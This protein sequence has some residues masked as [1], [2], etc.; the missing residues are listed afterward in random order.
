[1]NPNAVDS[2]T[3]NGAHDLFR[4]TVG[5]YEQFATEC[6]LPKDAFL[7][8]TDGAE[9]AF[10]DQV[11]AAILSLRSSTRPNA[12]NPDQK[13]TDDPNYNPRLMNLLGKIGQSVV[14]TLIASAQSHSYATP[15]K[16]DEILGKIAEA[17]RPEIAQTEA[18][19]ARKAK[20]GRAIGYKAFK[21]IVWACVGRKIIAKAY[22]NAANGVSSG[23]ESLA[24]SVNVNYDLPGGD[25]AANTV[26]V[27]PKKI[28]GLTKFGFRHFYQLFGDVGKLYSDKINLLPELVMACETGYSQ[29]FNDALTSVYPD[30]FKPGVDKNGNQTGHC[31]AFT[32]DRKTLAGIFNRAIRVVC[33]DLT[34]AVEARTELIDAIG[35]LENEPVMNL[36]FDQFLGMNRRESSKNGTVTLKTDLGVVS[37]ETAKME[38]GTTGAGSLNRGSDEGFM[39]ATGV[40]SSTKIENRGVSR[41]ANGSTVSLNVYGIDVTLSIDDSTEL[42]NYVLPVVL[43]M[44]FHGHER[45]W[46]VC[47]GLAPFTYEVDGGLQQDAALADPNAPA[48]DAASISE[49]MQHASENT[50]AGRFGRVADQISN[51]EP[52]FN[53]SEADRAAVVSD[54]HSRAESD[55]KLA[56]DASVA[57]G[58]LDSI[59]GSY[60]QFRHAVAEAF[61]PGSRNGTKQITTGNMIDVVNKV[62]KTIIID[63]LMG[64]GSPNDERAIREKTMQD[65]KASLISKWASGAGYDI[66]R[67]G[68]DAEDDKVSAV[69]ALMY[70]QAGAMGIARNIFGSYMQY[71]G[72]DPAKAVEQ[73]ES[74]AGLDQHAAELKNLVRRYIKAASIVGTS[75]TPD[76]VLDLLEQVESGDLAACA[77]LVKGSTGWFAEKLTDQMYAAARNQFD[78]WCLGF[79]Y[80]NLNDD[81]TP[82]RKV[83]E[84]VNQFYDSVA[85]AMFSKYDGIEGRDAVKK[86]VGAV[87]GALGTGAGTADAQGAVNEMNDFYTFSKVIELAAAATDSK[88]TEK[89]TGVKAVAS[90]FGMKPQFIE[91]PSGVHVEQPE[92]QKAPQVDYSEVIEE[93]NPGT[94]EAYG[95]GTIKQLVDRGDAQ[96][97]AVLNAMRLY[98]GSRAQIG[99]LEEIGDTTRTPASAETLI[100]SKVSNLVDKLITIVGDGMV[101]ASGNKAPGQAVRSALTTASAELADTERLFKFNA[102]PLFEKIL[103]GGEKILG[104]IESQQGEVTAPQAI[105]VASKVISGLDDALTQMAD[106][107]VGSLGDKATGFAGRKS[108]HSVVD[109]GL[110]N[111][112]TTDAAA[113][114]DDIVDS[115]ARLIVSPKA[116]N[117]YKDATENT[118]KAKATTQEIH[119]TMRFYNAAMVHRVDSDPS[120]R[121]LAAHLGQMLGYVSAD[122]ADDVINAKDTSGKMKRTSLK[123][124]PVKAFTGIAGNG[125]MN[126]LVNDIFDDERKDDKEYHGT[127]GDIVALMRGM[128]VGV[129]SK[130]LSVSSPDPES[131][132]RSRGDYNAKTKKVQVHYGP[133]GQ[134][135]TT[136]GGMTFEDIA[137]ACGVDGDF[138]A[139]NVPTDADMMSLIAAIRKTVAERIIDLS[140]DT[141][142]TPDNMGRFNSTV[143]ARRTSDDETLKSQIKNEL[144]PAVE[145]GS[146]P[147]SDLVFVMNGD[148]EREAVRYEL[149]NSGTKMYANSKFQSNG[150]YVGEV[151]PTDLFTAERAGKIFKVLSQLPSDMGED[152]IR[153]LAHKYF[154]ELGERDEIRHSRPEV[155]K[156]FG[157]LEEYDLIDRNDAT[158]DIDKIIE[159]FCDARSRA[160]AKN[161]TAGIHNEFGVKV[162]AEAAKI[163]GELPDNVSGEMFAKAFG[164]YFGSDASREKLKQDDQ[165]VAMVIA[166]LVDEHVI[167]DYLHLPDG[168]DQAAAVRSKERFVKESRAFIDQHNT[169]YDMSKAEKAIDLM[170]APTPKDMPQKEASAYRAKQVKEAATLFPHI[171]DIFVKAKQSGKAKT[172]DE[173]VELMRKMCREY[174]KVNP[175]DIKPDLTDKETAGGFKPNT[176]V[177]DYINMN[178]VSEDEAKD[179]VIDSL[180][181]LGVDIKYDTTAKDGDGYV[182]TVN[183]FRTSIASAMFDKAMKKTAVAVYGGEDARSAV[184]STL[185]AFGVKWEPV[186]KETKPA[187]KPVSPVSKA[188]NRYENMAYQRLLADEEKADPSKFKDHRPID[189]ETDERLMAEAE[190][191]SQIE[192]DKAKASASGQADF[193]KKVAA[194]HRELMA[195]QAAKYKEL[196]AANDPNAEAE[197]PERKSTQ[198]FNEARKFVQTQGGKE[199]K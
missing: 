102:A 70:D 185:N 63:M 42:D 92:A 54:I 35:T 48:E 187:P 174:A 105:F 136:P 10:M 190:R 37:I 129:Y 169:E 61:V 81:N 175:D 121:K 194:K 179:R 83:I 170:C 16:T 18:E 168:A 162:R 100:K 186:S 138:S 25:S 116:N 88:P 101:K 49:T 84:S 144:M 198:L 115:F 12:A 189:P 197:N 184:V 50:R 156:V 177:M 43:N 71:A 192:A 132:Y 118:R 93:G 56:D 40:A 108:R 4:K 153:S 154:T 99:K 78:E 133:D 59:K 96:S 57:L 182:I 17:Y 53:L 147:L 143:R 2:N 8:P 148:V 45:S 77:R 64:R 142:Y 111:V 167:P 110:S 159:Q 181:K 104:S 80:D 51:L 119:D 75:D 31:A 114:S 6:G 127:K 72:S 134:A 178:E 55:P 14:Y 152:E 20:L 173:Y 160:A 151:K 183:G 26:E 141:G 117:P 44:A 176:N 52:A 67:M 128:P 103:S 9:N 171:V 38:G 130:N 120:L 36:I 91:E 46:V 58:V 74:G 135:S 39:R 150:K 191:Q 139:V 95:L 131:D 7:K 164:E 65:V 172:R 122:D 165:D 27:A 140:V 146:I 5:L 125:I 66:K 145:K 126:L 28:N 157:Q 1:M 109:D 107:D 13:V 98:D 69:A 60:G 193:N 199:A 33:S 15:G 180:A 149:A 90:G 21:P 19:L 32:L 188:K 166:R 24:S 82:Y 62:S 47:K 87:Q 79:S 89:D 124:N 76:E 85:D 3:P 163:L 161:F 97:A 155:A 123:E 68:F 106:P 11:D 137:K 73:F 23:P 41:S 34:R 22:T 112:S 195:K 94:V 86:V 29:I 158:V 196:L 113:D 30:F